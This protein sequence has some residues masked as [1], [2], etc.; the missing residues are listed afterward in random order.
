ML[1]RLFGLTLVAAGIAAPA[2][3]PAFGQDVG[4][5]SSSALSRCAGRVGLETRQ[6]D[7]AFGVIALDGMPWLTVERT[8]DSIGTQP[9]STTVTG[10]GEYRRRNGTTV[11]FRFTCVLDDRGQ[12]LMFHASPLIRRL[13]DVLPPAIVVEG[14]ATYREK[15]TLPKGVELRV[16]LLDVAKSAAG[17]G[18]DE[19]G[20]EVLAEQVV[21]SGWQTPIPFALRLPRETSFEGRRLVI[22]ARLVLAHQVLFE[23]RQPLAVVGTDFLKPIELVLDKAGAPVR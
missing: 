23:L 18:P 14:M 13:G 5:V 6:S 19:R 7:A 4:G 15:T 2:L 10:T 12:A 3:A 1:L 22:A 8:E 20:G 16:Q 11:P 17:E 9:I 21:R